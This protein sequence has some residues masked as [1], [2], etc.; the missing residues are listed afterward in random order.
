MDFYLLVIGNSMRFQNDFIQGCCPSEDEME[1]EITIAFLQQQL[2]KLT[3][4]EIADMLEKIS[5]DERVDKN[6]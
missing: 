2:K 1:K 4:K 6:S 5:T 3:P